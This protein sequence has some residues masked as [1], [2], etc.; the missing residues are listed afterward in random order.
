[1]S[2]VF[3]MCAWSGLTVPE[4]VAG[5]GGGGF[6][7]PETFGDVGGW[8]SSKMTL[9]TAKNYKMGGANFKVKQAFHK[10]GIP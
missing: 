1:M 7:L 9:K 8:F 5:A 2:M 3:N 10:K 4:K 6:A